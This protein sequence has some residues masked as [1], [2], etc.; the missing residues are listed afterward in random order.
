MN[1]AGDVDSWPLKSDDTEL[2]SQMLRGVAQYIANSTDAASVSMV[3]DQAMSANG[4]IIGDFTVAQ[5]RADVFQVT[6]SFGAQAYHVG[7]LVNT[8]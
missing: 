8:T 1:Q 2:E 7:H 4:K 3:A 6:A 5:V